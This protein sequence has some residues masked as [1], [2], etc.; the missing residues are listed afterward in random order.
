MSDTQQ[1]HQIFSWL[2]WYQDRGI[3]YLPTHELAAPLDTLQK[4]KTFFV[5]EAG[6]GEQSTEVMS[7][8]DNI[9]K[10][11]KIDDQVESF[12]AEQLQGLLKE[13]PVKP[14][15]LLLFGAKALNQLLQ[16]NGL[17]GTE[18]LNSFFIVK[19]WNVPALLLD[20]PSAMLQNPR[21]KAPAWKAIQGFMK[22]LESSP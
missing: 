13:S 8:L 15:S 6:P 21:L 22:F 11:M 19:P 20:S 12:A 3:L 17:Q 1:Q 7:L 14:K 9:A 4:S 18:R 5:Y 10:A 16:S 2:K